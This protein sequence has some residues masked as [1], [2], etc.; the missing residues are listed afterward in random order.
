[1]TFKKKILAGYKKSLESLKGH[2]L[3]KNRFVKNSFQLVNSLAMSQLKES[4][5]E[6]NGQIMYIDKKDSLGSHLMDFLNQ[7]KLKLLK[8]KLKKMT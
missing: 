2:G 4:R 3:T 6:I 5:I 8:K 7:K 1:M